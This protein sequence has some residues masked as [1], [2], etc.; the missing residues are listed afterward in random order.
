M[1]PLETIALR[2]GA[3]RHRFDDRARARRRA[4]GWPAFLRAARLH[5]RGAAARRRALQRPR[6][7]RRARGRAV[8]ALRLRAAVLPV[9]TCAAAR[10]SGAAR[11]TRKGS[12]RRS[13][14]PRSGCAQRASGASACCSSSA[15]SGAVMAPRVANS[16]APRIALPDQ[17]RADRQPA[18]HRDARRAAGEAHA[19]RDARP[20]GRAGERRF[21]DRHAD[22]RA[23]PAANPAAAGRP[24]SRIDTFYTIGLIDGGVA[25]ERRLAARLRGVAVPDRRRLRTRS[26]AAI[27]PLADTVDISEVFAS[28]RCGCT[29]WKGYES[30]VFPFTT[31]VPLLGAWG[32]PLFSA[33]AC[34]WSHTP[35]RSIWRSTNSPPRSTPTCGSRGR[36]WAFARADWGSLG[37]GTRDW[38]LG[39][40]TWDGAA[41]NPEPWTEP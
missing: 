38:G 30:A 19:P 11:A 15:R 41:L 20:F 40:G 16:S 3:H 32:T 28:R 1:D 22:R 9:P 5:R 4:T 26:G 18:R 24:G 36:C 23:D 13:S 10:S 2:A 29:P 21:G 27:Q 6:H 35:T 25:P 17:R 14:R 12:W 31:D 33:R 8:H 7:A 34:S 39:T 37:A